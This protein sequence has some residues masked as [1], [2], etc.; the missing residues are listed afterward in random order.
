MSANHSPQGCVHRVAILMSPA[1][2]F[3]ECRDCLLTF[4]FPVGEPYKTIVKQFELHGCESAVRIRDRSEADI[5]TVL[6]RQPRHFIVLRYAGRVPAMAS[7]SHCERTFFTPANF[8][9]DEV[10]AGEY[11]RNKFDVHQC[12]DPE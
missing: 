2:R 9:R 10:G 3:L 1:G 5:A 8:L 11:L 6:N 12:G 4:N 7:C